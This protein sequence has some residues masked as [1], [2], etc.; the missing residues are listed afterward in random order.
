MSTLGICLTTLFATWIVK[1]WLD[2]RRIGARDGIHQIL[3]SPTTLLSN[4]SDLSSLPGLSSSSTF[5]LGQFQFWLNKRRWYDSGWD[6]CA[7]I[8]LFPNVKTTYVVGDPEVFKKIA[9]SRSSFPKSTD[10]Y[11]VLRVFGRNIVT[12]EGEEWKKYK[13]ICAPAFNE[14]NNRLVWDCSISTMSEFFEEVWRSGREDMT[15]AVKEITVDDFKVPCAQFT[16]HVIGA[17]A[18]G[19]KLSWKQANK[20]HSSLSFEVSSRPAATSVPMS[21]ITSI[22]PHTESPDEKTKL[23]KRMPIEKI[24][25]II[26]EDLFF[27]L[28]IPDWILRN[29]EWMLFP[30]PRF[31]DK[32][33]RV[34]EAF[35]GLNEFL[36]DIINARRNVDAETST[37]SAQRSDL[38]SNLIHAND[39]DAEAQNSK[40]NDGESL[41]RVWDSETGQ[42]VK[43]NEEEGDD[44]A[45]K[46]SEKRK[47]SDVEMM[48]NIFI[49]LLAG[50]ETSAHT[51][52]FAFA[53]LALYE[54]EQE[55]LY[56]HIM[57]VCPDGR[58][59]TYEDLPKLTRT[60][61]VLQETLRLFAPVI[62]I[63]KRSAE[64][65]TLVATNRH[66][67]EV[68]RIPV[69]RDAQI[70]LHTPGIHYNPK[71]WDNPADFNPNRFMPPSNW[72]REAFASF[73]S[74]TRACI[75]R[76]F[77]EI[78][79]IA[80]ITMLVIKYRVRIKPENRY[81]GETFEQR[82]ERV[83]HSRSGITLTPVRVPLVFTPRR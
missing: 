21:K 10:R 59:P 80:I 33:I 82:K 20:S 60:M 74:G 40:N 23:P 34:R 32:L 51:T 24:F 47:L 58:T 25:E 8:S 11:S 64:D 76:R 52:C 45:D 5:V 78:E 36:Q 68:L 29:A 46:E 30:L 55:K 63:P 37:G 71:Y 28:I 9:S 67:G 12:E 44:I 13:R 65:M 70:M 41:N 38:F 39:Q 18:F 15:G 69:E 54:E 16:L 19:Q 2:Y 77:A 22:S 43:F 14:R 27:K 6:V 75:G 42:Y 50:H 73:S 72:P 57:S 26:S 81:K 1:T 49:F 62:G 4:S 17:A 48:G 83:L 7:A 61:A 3:N 56:Q 35:D 66:T 53:L 31:K 79:S